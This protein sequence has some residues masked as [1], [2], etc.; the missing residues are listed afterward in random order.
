MTTPATKP[1]TRAYRAKQPGTMRVLITAR[2]NSLIFAGVRLVAVRHY[3]GNNSAA[4]EAL[5]GIGLHVS[6][7]KRV[8]AGYLKSKS[9]R[10]CALATNATPARPRAALASQ[11]AG[12]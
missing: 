7:E 10:G 3:N 5:L 11:H 4:A 6:K 9:G 12:E 1:N 8:R 2:V